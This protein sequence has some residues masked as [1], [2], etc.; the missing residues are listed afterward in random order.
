MK[1]KKE[2]GNFQG[3]IESPI[4]PR[5]YTTK[6]NQGTK[7]ISSKIEKE[8]EDEERKKERRKKKKKEKK[9]KRKKEK[10]RK[11]KEKGKRHNCETTRSFN[12][13]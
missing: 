12:S 7:L 9:K 13:T 2:L 5:K 10:K 4:A 6:I 3:T 8:E 11:G 1:K